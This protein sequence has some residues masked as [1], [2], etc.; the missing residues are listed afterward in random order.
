MPYTAPVTDGSNSTVA[1]VLIFTVGFV[2]SR[3]MLRC[4][5]HRALI[6]RIAGKATTGFGFCIRLMGVTA[7]IS[8]V[9]PNVITVLAMIPVIES[10]ARSLPES[11]RNRVRTALGLAVVYATSIGS[12][13]TVIGSP[14]NGLLLGILAYRD[15]PG[16]ELITPARWSM[17]GVP[18]SFLFFGLA[19][20][21][22]AIAER[23]ALRFDP[24]AIVLD[25]PTDARDV[26]FGVLVIAVA[27]ISALVISQLPTP[28]WV[29][30][31]VAVGWFVATLTIPLPSGAGPVLR[32]RDI[33]SEIPW[34]GVVLVGA[35]ITFGVVLDRIGA[36][37][38][39]VRFV[40]S[41]VPDVGRV[42]ATL[43]MTLA[44]IF[45]TEILSNTAT[46]LA[47]WQLGE[48]LANAGG[49]DALPL[50]VAVGIASN[51]AFMSP[52]ATGATAMVFGGIK[53]LR[54]GRMLLVGAV[55]NISGGLLIA[56]YAI[57]VG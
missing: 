41:I 29:L 12:F 20:A 4:G 32:P 52:L 54:F 47:M 8:A 16:H 15:I 51:C 5:I 30:I 43:S 1:L 19:A 39:S 27:V 14:A 28:L 3:I 42:A 48:A 40:A 24:T 6:E 34:R 10:A 56:G 9:V 26:R 23:S 37:D 49:F 2:A 35:A 22:L 18:L 7:L 17:V 53:G 13:A 46:A 36:V 55:L 45:L 11:Q 44:T 33:V 25:K 57:L 31:A 21:V 38:A 50:M